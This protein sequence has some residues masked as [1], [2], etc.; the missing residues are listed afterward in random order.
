MMYTTEILWLISWPV[1]IWLSYKV[2]RLAL[3]KFEKQ[4]QKEE[5]SSD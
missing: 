5:A 4:E 2:V 3:N 1:I